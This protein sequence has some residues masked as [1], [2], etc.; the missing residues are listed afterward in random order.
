MYVCVCVSGSISVGETLESALCLCSWQLSWD[1]AA[2]WQP[3]TGPPVK[4]NLI[5][6]I[7]LTWLIFHKLRAG[8]TGWLWRGM[9]GNGWWT[10]KR[11]SVCSR[12]GWAAGGEEA[13]LGWRT[14]LRQMPTVTFPDYGYTQAGIPATVQ[15]PGGNE[16]KDLGWILQHTWAKEEGECTYMVVCI[17]HE[18]DTS[19]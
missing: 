9:A 14:S 7:V 15:R 2:A 3:L 17:K 18:T 16:E 6:A 10:N 11:A 12:G 1:G 5:N 19:S 13:R 4:N 8:Q